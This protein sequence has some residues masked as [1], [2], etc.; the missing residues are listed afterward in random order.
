LRENSDGTYTLT[1]GPADTN[2]DGLVD[3]I[4]A[5]GIDLP[6]PDEGP[7]EAPDDEDELA[8][9]DKPRGDAA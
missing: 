6:D 1:G 4:K 9:W 7:S 3:A 8:K 2:E 5:A